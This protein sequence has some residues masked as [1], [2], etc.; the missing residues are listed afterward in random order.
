[1]Y[2]IQEE[3]PE[4]TIFIQQDY[5]V[6]DHHLW[7]LGFVIFDGL[8]YFRPFSRIFGLVEVTTWIRTTPSQVAYTQKPQA[9]CPPNFMAM[10]YLGASLGTSPYADIS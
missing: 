5:F 4:N 7:P 9:L 3:G 8:D 2:G 10:A 6:R 1:M